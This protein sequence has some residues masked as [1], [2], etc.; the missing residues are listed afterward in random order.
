[1]G[2]RPRSP[3]GLVWPSARTR[4]DAAG[5]SPAPGVLR[6]EDHARRTP[7]L[8]EWHHRGGQFL[9]RSYPLQEI[10][11]PSTSSSRPNSVMI[12][13]ARPSSAIITFADPRLDPCG[14]RRDVVV[15]H[16]LVGDVQGL[17]HLIELVLQ[18]G[19]QGVVSREDRGVGEPVLAGGWRPLCGTR[20]GCGRTSR[21]RDRPRRGPSRV[22][23]TR[24]SRRGRSA[25]RPGRTG[26]RSG[27][28]AGECR[29]R[30]W[31]IFG[32]L[33]SSGDPSASTTARGDRR[34]D[35]GCGLV[36][37]DRAPSRFL[38]EQQR[39]LASPLAEHDGDVVAFDG[40]QSRS[41]SLAQPHGRIGFGRGSVPDVG[42]ILGA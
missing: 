13:S 24:W 33:R 2:L 7:D 22:P 38:A 36:G 39:A 17:D 35:G 14:H 23:R 30:R 1:M 12:P 3:R 16:L 20:D 19:D 26:N 27:Q 10:L 4:A 29:R 32:D 9:D 11:L 6:D 5:W 41:E 8:G 40:L 18:G 42:A 28:R 37:S 34:S 25:A 15:R 31:S 21:R